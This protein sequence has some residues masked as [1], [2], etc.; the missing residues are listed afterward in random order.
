MMHIHFWS[1]ILAPMVLTAALSH[2]V[3]STSNSQSS[4]VDI[5]AAEGTFQASESPSFRLFGQRVAPGVRFPNSQQNHLGA[6]SDQSTP[7]HLLPPSRELFDREIA[8]IMALGIAGGDS[9]PLQ[10]NL[11]DRGSLEKLAE[12][13][14]HH[15][16]NLDSKFYFYVT[17]PPGGSST[18]YLAKPIPSGYFQQH[19]F[20]HVRLDDRS[21]QPFAVFKTQMG[22]RVL[23]RGV[24][25]QIA[26]VELLH[27]GN[28]RLSFERT[29]TLVSVPLRLIYQYIERGI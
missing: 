1:S 6:F 25:T 19:I 16:R 18:I 29:P 11:Y 24:T 27:I 20:P 2:A 10:S 13:S 12:W 8:R 23:T 21:L 7:L 4:G 9:T 17:V 3:A 26:G 5:P 28:T 14:E 22:Q 15:F